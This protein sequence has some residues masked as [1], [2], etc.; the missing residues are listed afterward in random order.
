MFVVFDNFSLCPYVIFRYRY[1]LLITR[2]LLDAACRYVAIRL[3]NIAALSYSYY[4]RYD[5]SPRFLRHYIDALY[6]CFSLHFPD[7]AE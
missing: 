2:L 1:Y 3:F 6:A 7:V 4:L 5:M